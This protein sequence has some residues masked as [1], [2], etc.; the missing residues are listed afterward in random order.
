MNQSNKPRVSD[1]LFL[2]VKPSL[3]IFCSIVHSEGFRMGLHGIARNLS[4]ERRS[5]RDS[6][7]ASVR[8]G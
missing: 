5:D 8:R 3:I 6:S 4:I 1:I 7:D 2:I